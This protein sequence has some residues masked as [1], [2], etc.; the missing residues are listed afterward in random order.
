[1]RGVPF[2]GRTDDAKVDKHRCA[3]RRSNLNGRRGGNAH[4]GVTRHKNRGARQQA[5]RFVREC[6]AAAG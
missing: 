4:G 5:P 2:S 3:D 6:R 1:M